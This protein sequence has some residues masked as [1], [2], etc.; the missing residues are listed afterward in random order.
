[1]RRESWFDDLR[2]FDRAVGLLE[3]VMDFVAV[4]A[5]AEAAYWISSV[6]LPSTAGNYANNTI[7]TTSAGFA[8]LIVLLLEK[9]GDYQP[10]L[11]LLAV[12]ETERLLRVTIS[13]VLLAVP[14]FVLVT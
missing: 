1:M 4:V 5:T 6:W 13:A 14:I 8:L 3:R 2:Y 10:W 12:R 7:L 9:H 11:S